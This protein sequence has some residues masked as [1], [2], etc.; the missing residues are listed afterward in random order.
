LPT[1]NTDSR[2]PPHIIGIIHTG[3]TI[4]FYLRIWLKARLSSRIVMLD[5]QP[6]RRG[7]VESRATKKRN[8]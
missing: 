5:H 6:A 8:G 2:Q 3:D 4:H 7:S 1:I